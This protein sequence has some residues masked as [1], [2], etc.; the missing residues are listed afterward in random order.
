MTIMIDRAVDVQTDTDAEFDLEDA[1]AMESEHELDLGDLMYGCTD[2]GYHKD[3]YVLFEDTYTVTRK[4]DDCG[5]TWSED[6]D[7]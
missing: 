1:T 3:E 6:K 2:G 5:D 7:D 4:C